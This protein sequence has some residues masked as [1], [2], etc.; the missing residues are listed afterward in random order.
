MLKHCNTEFCSTGD[1]TLRRVQKGPC[2]EPRG[3]HQQRPAP[4]GPPSPPWT[5]RPTPS[6]FPPSAH[7]LN[8]DHPTDRRRET[9]SG[10]AVQPQNHGKHISCSLDNHTFKFNQ[11][12][13]LLAM[14]K[15]RYDYIYMFPVA[16]L[17]ECN[18]SFFIYANWNGAV[19]MTTAAGRHLG[20]LSPD[21]RRNRRRLVSALRE[22]TQHSAFGSNSRSG[23][24]NE[25]RDEQPVNL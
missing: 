25:C 22:G 19:H 14:K 10:G 3:C 23:F 21:L 8:P 16:Q 13:D 24:N 15:K 5:R 9:F 1:G 4:P 17:K 20:H 12:F 6:L 7:R 11:I 2:S 18:R